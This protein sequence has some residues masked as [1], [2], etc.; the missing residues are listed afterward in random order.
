M[1]LSVFDLH[2]DTP[3]LMFKRSEPLFSNRLAVSMEKASAFGRYVQVMALWTDD[4]LTDADGW[5]QMQRMLANLQQDPALQSK[6]VDLC[7]TFS[8][9]AD[10]SRRL[11]LAVE[12]ARILDGKLERVDALYRLGIRV[13]T[14]LWRGAT[15]IGGSH[16]TAAG[17][18]PFG[19]AALRQAARNG[20]ILDI[21]HASERS[22]QN[23]FEIAQD[24][25]RPAIASHSNAYGVCDVSRNL[26]DW[27]ID[28]IVK[29]GGLIGL[30]FYGAFLSKDH[31]PS[32]KTI[33][34]HIDYFLARGGE[35]ALALGGDMD[36]CTL[37]ND[38]Q[39]LASLPRLVGLMQ[40]HGYSDELIQKIFFENANRFFLK[41]L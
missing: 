41:Y 39:D 8:D 25:G 29:S 18:T 30:N 28:H 36:G 17:L 9:H 2:C 31:D 33:L 21:S 32:I 10:S 37:P 40:R 6:A 27:Q 20:M 26:R 13:L 35:N 14:P 1:E 5:E 15:V 12:D 38:M 19:N 4:E 24:F 34:S 3:Y 16:D 22:A 23:I 11:L 7:D